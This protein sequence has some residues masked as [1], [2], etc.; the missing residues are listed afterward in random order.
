MHM[1]ITL[2]LERHA[3]VP[4]A[5]ETSVDTAPRVVKVI[6]ATAVEC[7]SEKV[8]K[9]FEV[10]RVERTTFG[11]DVCTQRRRLVPHW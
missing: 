1:E 3:P 9:D 6:C 4:R 8:T 7:V 5:S 10:E 11:I 2:L